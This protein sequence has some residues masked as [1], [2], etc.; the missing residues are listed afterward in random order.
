MLS[1]VFWLFLGYLLSRTEN[2]F[3]T[4]ER[5]LSELGRI[6]YEAYWQSVVLDFFL[7]QM[8]K[9]DEKTSI[10]GISH[11]FFSYLGIFELTI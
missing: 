6:S 2:Q 5:P 7:D 3:G 4:P 10:K 8:K 9:P 11:G 1:F